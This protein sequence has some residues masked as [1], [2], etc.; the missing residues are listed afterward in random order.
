M[1][2]ASL[3]ALLALHF[4]IFN[5]G[6]RGD[7]GDTTPY[8]VGREIEDIDAVITAAGGSASVYGTS[9]GAALALK[10]ADNRHG[11]DL[12]RAGGGGTMRCGRSTDLE[13]CRIK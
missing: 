5:Y 2:N 11:E 4:T 1:A 6:R 7:S 10:A 3:A 12:H 9:S 13:R 8:A